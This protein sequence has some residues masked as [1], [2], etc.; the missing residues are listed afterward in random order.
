VRVVNIF[1]ALKAVRFK[2]SDCGGGSGG[3]GVCDDG[4]GCNGGASGSNGAKEEMV[5]WVRTVT[6]GESSSD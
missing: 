6:G 5:M 4:N 2:G 3:I 1:K